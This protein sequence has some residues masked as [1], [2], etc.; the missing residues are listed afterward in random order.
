[1]L[2]DNNW[3]LPGLLRPSELEPSRRVSLHPLIWDVRWMYESVIP[4]PSEWTHTPSFSLKHIPR[5]TD[6]IFNIYLFHHRLPP[7]ASF[8]LSLFSD[9][10][11]TGICLSSWCVCHVGIS[12]CCIHF[13]E[14]S[15]F[16]L[17][18]LYVFT[19]LLVFFVWSAVN[20]IWRHKGISR[21]LHLP[22]AGC[23]WGM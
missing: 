12:L 21:K 13:I 23:S 5:L 20:I 14:V 8:S 7:T 3:Q 15:L 18:G 2:W 9:P 10:Q 17:K 11:L 19:S 1:M 6:Y 4:C 16:A 22:S